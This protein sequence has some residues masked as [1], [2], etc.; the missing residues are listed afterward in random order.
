MGILKSIGYLAISAVALYVAGWALVAILA[1][2]A[3]F[4][5]ILLAVGLVV[6]VI[7]VIGRYCGNRK[8]ALQDW[9]KTT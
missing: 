9:G 5:G 8:V 7:N 2:S 4:F 3:V 1:A 6:L